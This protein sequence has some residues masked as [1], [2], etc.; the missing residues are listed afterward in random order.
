MFLDEVT[1]KKSMQ[2]LD[3][4]NELT[5]ET[6]Q[7]ITPEIFQKKIDEA[8]LL[9]D[10]LLESMPDSEAVYYSAMKTEMQIYPDISIETVIGLNF[11]EQKAAQKLFREHV[12]YREIPEVLAHSLASVLTEKSHDPKIIWQAALRKTIEAIN[13]ICADKNIA[14]A[15]PVSWLAKNFVVDQPSVEEV[16]AIFLHTVF[17]KNPQ[18]SIV[19][20]DKAIKKELRNFFNPENKSCQ[21]IE[22]Y[23]KEIIDDVS[24]TIDLNSNPEEEAICWTDL[25]QLPK[26][27]VGELTKIISSAKTDNWGKEEKV[28]AIFTY[29]AKSYIATRMKECLEFVDKTSKEI[30]NAQQDVQ[31]NTRNEEIILQK[32]ETRLKALQGV[33]YKNTAVKFWEQVLDTFEKSLIKIDLVKYQ[34]AAKVIADWSGTLVK[35]SEEMALADNPELKKIHERA[36]AVREGAEKNKATWEQLAFLANKLTSFSREML[37]ATREQVLRNPLLKNPSVYLAEPFD[38]LMQSAK[39][40]PRDIYCS[41]LRK[42]VLEHPGIGIFEADT[43]VLKI[44]GKFKLDKLQQSII[45][46]HSPRYRN[47][48][49]PSR[50]NQALLF[51]QS[52]HNAKQAER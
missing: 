49:E 23:L 2:V 21:T 3:L 5:E 28:E 31:D 34:A 30:G 36:E 25:L 42:A 50:K 17:R 22:A 47:M 46:A 20:A 44:L 32:M 37:Q 27:A 41:A 1:A 33:Q 29:C 26:E 16:Y 24:V 38:K 11:L 12:P 43:E 51:I 6:V 10:L 19:A 45:M 4:P 14:S 52:Q 39:H 18:Q 13:P 9:D 48:P 40:K 8:E 7:S 35:A 15:M